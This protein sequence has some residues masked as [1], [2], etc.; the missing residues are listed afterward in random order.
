MT[1]KEIFLSASKVKLLEEC[2]WKYWCN[3][4]LGIPQAKNEGAIRGTICHLIFELLIKDRHSK[5]FHC[6]LKDRGINNCLVIKRLVIKHLEKDNVNTEENYNLISDM[7]YIGLGLEFYGGNGKVEDTEVEFSIRNESPTYKIRG[8]I[9]KP[10]S[11]DKGKKL[12]IIDYKSSKKKFSALELEG[13]IQAM[14]YTLAA[15]TLWPKSEDVM[16]EFQF[17]RFPKQPLQQI[18]INEDQLRGFEY[19]LE[20]VYKIAS[21]FKEDDAKVNY[22]SS[23]RKKSWLCKAGRTWRCPYL[24]PMEYYALLDGEGNVIKTSLNK[25]FNIGEGQS[26]KT[27]KYDG[28]PAHF[29]QNKGQEIKD[30]F[31]F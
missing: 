3:Y 11:Y 1:K 8:F 27:L 5:H 12:K 16:V 2:S 23:D 4:H 24:D 10:V 30:S 19:Y 9:D 17:L 13:N 25:D 20:H 28:C 21:N 22:A 31:D 29:H 26:V 18:K 15:K 6:I 14:A 7:L